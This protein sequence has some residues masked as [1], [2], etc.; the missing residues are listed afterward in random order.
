M[1]GSSPT[2]VTV[3]LTTTCSPTASTSKPRTVNVMAPSTPASTGADVGGA[4]QPLD[5]IDLV[6]VSV[7][8]L[9]EATNAVVLMNNP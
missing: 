4:T 3:R 8:V 6:G 5:A 7:S 1:A 2:L 9:S